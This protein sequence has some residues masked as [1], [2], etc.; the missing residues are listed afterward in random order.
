MVRS[1]SVIAH[2]HRT[3]SFVVIEATG[4]APGA[5]LNLWASLA[6][7]TI[8]TVALLAFAAPASATTSFDLAT[9]AGIR[10]GVPQASN[11][12]R[13][14]SGSVSLFDAPTNTASEDAPAGGTVSTNATTSPTDPLGTSVTT[15][16]AG[17]VT[18]DEGDTTSSTP[19]GYSL[20]GQEVVITAPDASAAD[21]LV[22]DFRLD[23][24]LVP[25]GA[26]ETTVQ[27]FRNGTPLADCDSGAG[28]TA[29]PDPC[30]AIRAATADGVE[31]TVRTSQA[32][33]WSFGVVDA[34]P[35]DTTIDSGPSGP[36]NDPTPTFAFSSSQAGSSF[37]CKLDS[38]GYASCSSPKTITPQISPQS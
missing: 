34:T 16:V 36:T 4:R 5:V 27:V 3:S 35:P 10:I 8:A 6:G 14:R 32:S 28:S 22:I 21:P 24:S 13:S 19:P 9:H 18:I 38:G 11:K 23:A 17:T 7:A 15:P 1:G 25:P 26:D 33:T 30:V 2:H 37:Q 31:F 12:A 29:A 20:L